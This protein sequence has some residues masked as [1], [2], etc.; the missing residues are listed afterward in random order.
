MKKKVRVLILFFG[1]L[2]LRLYMT[3]G[4]AYADV[5]ADGFEYIADYFAETCKITGYTGT[6]TEIVFPS[7]IDGCKVIEITG[8]A[9]TGNR[10]RTYNVFKVKE[11]TTVTSVFIPEGVKVIGGAS[12]YKCLALEKV[13][14]PNTLEKIEVMAFT[15]TAIKEI[16]IPGNVKSFGGISGDSYGYG[17]YGVFN[18]CN[19]LKKV[20]LKKGVEE[21]GSSTFR[22][23]EALETVELPNTLTYIGSAAFL[24]NK[25]L[26][27]LDLPNSLETIS[28]SSFA[29]CNNLTK[30]SF[31]SG[32]T[33]IGSYAFK[34]CEKLKSVSLKENVTKIHNNAFDGCTSLNTVKLSEALEIIGSYAFTDC[35]NLSNVIF[36]N[37]LQTIQRNAFAGTALK[38][39]VI[40]D[41]VT[42]IDN[43]VFSDCNDLA[44]AYI[45]NSNCSLSG[46]TS[47]SKVTLYGLKDSKVQEYAKEI[48][49][50][51]RTLDLPTDLKA[52]NN[53]FKSIKL[54]WSKVN[55]VK[56]YVIYRSTSEN[57]TYK[58]L[59]I[60]TKNSYIDKTA[61]T[62]SL[63]YYKIEVEHKDA[64]GNIISGIRTPAVAATL[65]PE[66]PSN[67]KVVKNTNVSFT[68]TWDKVKNADGYVIYRWDSNTDKYKKVKTIKK[69]STVSYKD[70]V[71]YVNVTHKYKVV[72]YKKVD[73][74]TIYS[75]DSN[76]VSVR[77]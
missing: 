2:L 74:K 33:S 69:Q 38:T 61:N 25:S 64:D 48:G 51:F 34:D 6:E 1:V 28:S 42:K 20:V 53:K 71:T 26:K 31:G 23:C 3:S 35:T 65:R 24:G 70:K 43:Y 46:F 32:L 18:G 41:S 49:V 52:V 75:F 10:H 14:L 11:N 77:N 13:T 73:K 37:G 5:T 44:H 15:D 22:N 17:W 68:L 55:G 60:T 56:N 30:V 67:L 76:I 40:P 59:G 7:E 72:S 8:D 45:L 9:D 21:I 47:N 12:F 36:N 19:S 58:K 57:G 27:E 16:V 4:I 63:Y 50:R 29:Y 54:S 66:V 62:K 39:I